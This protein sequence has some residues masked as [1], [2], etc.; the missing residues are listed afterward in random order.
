[1]TTA[2]DALQHVTD[3]HQVMM[4]DPFWQYKHEKRTTGS[5]AIPCQKWLAE[6]ETCVPPL[7]T[8]RAGKTRPPTP[9]LERYAELCAL[10]SEEGDPAGPAAGTADQTWLSLE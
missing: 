5:G 7:D 9:A 3:L 8:D 10:G 1:V 6:A 2:T 4:S